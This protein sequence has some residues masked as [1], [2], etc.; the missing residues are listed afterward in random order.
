MLTYRGDKFVKGKTYKLDESLTFIRRDDDNLVFESASN[1]LIT[2]TESEFE[3]KLLEKINQENK[4]I[5]EII[6][7]VLRSKGLARK[8]EDLL[9]SK[10]ITIDY[11]SP[12]GVA[13][14]GP[15]GKILSASSKEVYGPHTPDNSSEMYD[16]NGYNR[17]ADG[18]RKNS[19]NYDSYY[20]DRAEE[21]KQNLE[22]LKAMK[23]DDIIRK[24][25]DKTSKEALQ[26]HK[27][28][29]KRTEERIKDY[30]DSDKYN[31]NRFERSKRN[32]KAERRNAN[33]GVLRTNTSKEKADAAMDYLNYLTKPAND[34]ADSN[35]YNYYGYGERSKSN[36]TLQMNVGIDDNLK[37]YKELKDRINSAKHDVDWHTY[38]DSK[39]NSYNSSYAAMSDEQLENKIKAMRDELEKK[40]EELRKSNKSNST[41]RDAEVKELEKREKDLDKF[42]KSKGIRESVELNS[43]ETYKDIYGEDADYTQMRKMITALYAI[44]EQA[45]E[46]GF[47]FTSEF[48]KAIY[49]L[50]DV[51]ENLEEFYEHTK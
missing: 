49:A 42:L 31:K 33:V 15:N 34:Y 24:Y 43:R 35:R 44:L 3:S 16:K 18:H 10:G 32:A 25:S 11:S 19:E 8:Y 23:R 13:L 30:L 20:A 26:A 46:D 51:C 21:E 38:D 36:P 22:K 50:S 39:S 6:G 9:K 7:K 41:K 28:E 48:E 27:D 14:T 4:D 47:N 1:K 37:Q 40:I 2:M 45:Q 29:I 17:R 12:Q 5:N